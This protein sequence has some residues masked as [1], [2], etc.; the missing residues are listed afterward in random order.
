VLGSAGG[1]SGSLF[2]FEVLFS[3]RVVRFLLE[4]G[5]HQDHEDEA[6]NRRNRLPKGINPSDIDFVIISHAHIDHSGWLPA[7]VKMGFKGPV[8]THPATRDLLEILLPDSGRLQ[9]DAAERATKRARRWAEKRAQQGG[10]SGRKSS[11][12]PKYLPL[13]TEEDAKACF[14][15][16]KSIHYNQLYHI[17]DGITMRFTEAS[18]ILGAA[19][20]TLAIGK[21]SETRTICFT[22]NIGRPNTPLLRELEAVLH[23][24]YVISESTYGGKLHQ[25]RNRRKVLAGI[26]NP[27]YE[28]AKQKEKRTGCGAIVIPAFA[29]GRVQ[30][31]LNDLR[32]LMLTGEIPE[33]PVYL[34][35]KMAIASTA[36]HRKW[37]SLYNAETRAVFARGDDP[38]KTPRYFECTEDNGIGK[39]LVEGKLE[40]PVIIVGSS[41]MAAGGKIQRHL[42]M[43]L[44]QRNSTVIFVGYQ[45]TGVLGY[46][47]VNEASKEVRIFGKT[48]PVNAKVEYM[49]DY[50]GHADYEE[51]IGWLKHFKSKPKAIFLV[52]GEPSSL[53]A[54]KGHIEKALGWNVVVPQRRQCIELK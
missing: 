43:R 10:K 26:I 31:V 37:H 8:Y 5:L 40:E 52:H 6:L 14:K 25:K 42:Q 13:Y 38:F 33:M 11:R 1:V 18:H 17:T 20:V 54:L 51:I 53:A 45:G 12:I 34:D 32:E 22:G 36:I 7:L 46:K 19:V 24:D 3:A 21:D 27:A 9:E 16:I 28:R 30:T 49:P 48:I 44:P 47:L 2:L 50:S 29:V 23:A 15:N 4:V 35:S 39:R 41:G